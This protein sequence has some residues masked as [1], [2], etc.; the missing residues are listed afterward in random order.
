MPIATPMSGALERRCI[1]H[2]VA[3]HR[4]HVVLLLEC[5]HDAELVL[6]R[7]PGE[8]R[9]VT[10]GGGELLVV[11]MIEFGA[12]EHAIG[13]G[14][15]EL[16]G[17]RH[18]GQGVVPRDHHRPDPGTP[19]YRDGVAHL[20]SW[21]VDDADQPE[22]RDRGLG[23]DLVGLHDPKSDAEHSHAG[24]GERVV[25]LG[26]PGAPVIVDGDD[27]IAVPDAGRVVEQAVDRSLHEGDATVLWQLGEFDGTP[28]QRAVHGAHPLAGRVER[29]LVDTGHG[30]S[31]RLDVE[32]RVV[33]G[34]EERRLGGVTHEPDGAIGVDVQLTVVAQQCADEQ[35]TRP[36]RRGPDRRGGIGVELHLMAGHVEHGDRHLVLGERARLVGADHRDRAE[37]LDSGQ[38]ADERMATQ[39]ALR[40]DGERERDDG[41]KT[42]GDDCDSDADRGQ[43]QVSG[44]FTSDRP[45][46]HDGERHGH[47]DQGEL[48]ADPIEA[49][50]QRR[51]LGLH[52]LQQA[53]DVPQLGAHTG[54]DD[55]TSTP[56]GA[57][58]GTR[59]G[60]A[61][62]I[63][64]REVVS[65]DLVDL[66]VD[67]LRLS[68][69]R[70]LLD[71]QAGGFDE[72]QVGGHDGAGVEVDDV[73]GDEFDPRVSERSAHPET[74]GP[75]GRRVGAARR[76]PAPR[77][78][79]G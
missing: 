10:H 22:E 3:R 14:D 78:T 12:D 60:H 36:S 17:D 28:G 63:A 71:P 37:R 33:G 45:H 19:A 48:L 21:W 62:A 40:A 46:R 61:Q 77:G 58:L 35:R 47:P 79:P 32:P 64:E 34:L 15:A 6:G 66:L 44:R 53:G 76:W 51:L 13:V 74:P 27:A 24:R 52:T 42:F 26:D 75:R 43:H 18:G 50:L 41:G 39:H 29:Q 2:T 38:L 4:N 11:E 67:R 54:R 31:Q 30:L 65:I 16:G 69:E 5:G 1:V 23:V 25:R 55:H 56:P 72:A 8:H 7:H 9:H 70:R 20:L 73:A 49:T 68:R 57:D 59:V